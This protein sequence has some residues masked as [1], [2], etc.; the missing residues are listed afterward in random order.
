MKSF[1][2]A[3]KQ[4]TMVMQETFMQLLEEHETDHPAHQ[5]GALDETSRVMDGF[6][7]SLMRLLHGQALHP[8]LFIEGDAIASLKILPSASVDTVITSPPYWQQREYTNPDCIGGE[9]SVE[10]YVQS[11][12]DVFSEVHRVLKKTGSFWLNIGDTYRDKNLCAIPWRVAIALQDTQGWILR[13]DVVWNK[14]KGAP[15]NTKDK[16]RNVHEFV[17]H[18]VKQKNYYYNDLAVRNKPRLPT[19]QNGKVV[20]ATGVSGI[21]YRRQIQR[22]SALNDKEKAEA[23]L[24]LEDTLHKVAS[25]EMP[26]FRMIIRGQQ[27]TTHSDS[28][29]VSGRASEIAKK[30]FCILPYDKQGTKY[31]DVWEII[32]EDEW[33]T[34]SHCAP[35]PE[36]LCAIPIE[37]TCPPGGV[38]LDPFCGTG[39]SILSAVKRQRK[40]IGLDISRQYI[41]T[42]KSRLK[43]W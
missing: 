2:R 17:F 32:P 5:E 42:S 31:D 18:F 15:D 36:E 4:T 3:H 11:L 35:F 24:T 40:G 39:T 29:K 34:D 13:N 28:I 43:M 7:Q 25:G 27:R 8:Y 9:P 6:E 23:L 26:D 19:I 22:S 21:N 10:S 37:A 30:G 16:L 12:L 38:V 20:T 41:E 33:R 14:L 1:S